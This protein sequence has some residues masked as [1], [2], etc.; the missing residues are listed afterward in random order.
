M[1]YKNEKHQIYVTIMEKGIFLHAMMDRV[2]NCT[3]PYAKR[4]DAIA[5]IFNTC[6]DFMMAAHCINVF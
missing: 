4:Q 2:K 6:T 3:L 5:I 1:A